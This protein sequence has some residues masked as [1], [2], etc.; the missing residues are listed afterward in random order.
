MSAPQTLTEDR[1]TVDKRLLPFV[2]GIKGE[3]CP[4]KGYSV[5]RRKFQNPLLIETRC[6]MKRCVPCGPAVRAH[7]ALKAEIG[8]WIRGGSYFITITNKMGTGLQKDAASVQEDWRRFLYL[9]KRKYPEMTEKM[10]W[11]KVV[12]LTKAGQP[13]LHVIVTGLP[14]GI[15]DRCKGRKNEREWVVQ[16]CWQRTGTC[17]LHAVAKTWLET[18]KGS[19][20]VCDASKVRSASSAGNY[21]GKYIT[22]AYEGTELAK[23]GFK[24]VWS[25]SQGFAPDLRVR[26][27]GA[28]AG[29]WT[30]VEHFFSKYDQSDWLDRGR[31]D[32]DLKLVGHPLVM[33]KIERR[34][35]QRKLKEVEDIQRGITNNQQ[36]VN[37]D[38]GGAKQRPG[39]RVRAASAR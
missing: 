4:R 27:A 3:D 32:P 26:L 25:A 30:K 19:S 23:L 17:L 33:E 2:K 16:G 10:H 35:R 7:V 11:M 38:F 29:K 9:F 36:A 18:T 14:G 21:V 15:V 39:R 31:N 24:R 22:K 6:K 12:E 1:I 34:E 37:G 28:V 5:L 20:W 8:S 13:H